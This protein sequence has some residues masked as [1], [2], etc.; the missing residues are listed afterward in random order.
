MD[1]D[2]SG[3][4][5]VAPVVVLVPTASGGVVNDESASLVDGEDDATGT[6]LAVML[7]EGAGAA[8]SAVPPEDESSE[9]HPTA[10]PTAS[11]LAAATTIVR[12]RAI[13]HPAT[14]A[15]SRTITQSRRSGP[16]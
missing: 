12:P 2:K 16:V 4:D 3:A 11:A 8:L 10:P 6:A 13:L 9:L 15:P 14:R 5:V 7:A 1:V